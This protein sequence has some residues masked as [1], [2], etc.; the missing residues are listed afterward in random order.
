MAK[1]SGMD[2]LEEVTAAQRLSQVEHPRSYLGM[3]SLGYQC[4]R[5]IWFNWRWFNPETFTPRM[6]RLFS[7]GHNTEQPIIDLLRLVDFQVWDVDPKTGEQWEFVAHD[8]HIKGH[9][10]SVAERHQKRMVVEIK[11]HNVNSFRLV[12]KG[13][14]KLNKIEHFCQAQRYMEALDLDL[15]LYCATCKN[16]DSLYFEYIYR[17]EKTIKWLLERERFLLEADEIPGG[18]SEKDTFWIC[19]MCWY[20][21]I[22]YANAKPVANCRTCRFSELAEK[23]CWKCSKKEKK[24]TMS[25]TEQWMGCRQHCHF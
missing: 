2:L 3:S 15:G 19:K 7:R 12:T 8:G 17:D 4:Q 23:G 9:C 21:N 1:L 22:C 18:I 13:N 20:N 25:L 11:T 16:N 14:L 24:G 10:D 6:L 5:A